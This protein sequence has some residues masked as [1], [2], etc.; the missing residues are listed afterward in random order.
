MIVCLM[1]SQL[2]HKTS[3]NID[4]YTIPPL[5]LA[6]ADEPG[7]AVVNT[8]PHSSQHRIRDTEFRT[9]G[10]D[11]NYY[12]N[13]PNPPAARNAASGIRKSFSR[14]TCSLCVWLRSIM[15]SISPRIRIVRTRSDFLII[16][17]MLCC[18]YHSRI[19]T[20]TQGAQCPRHMS[21]ACGPREV[22]WRAGDRNLRSLTGKTVRR[23]VP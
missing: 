11:I 4:L 15:W 16:E 21:V 3:H 10:R 1:A 23:L 20:S 7:R 14:R 6:M 18:R 5:H 17:L 12:Y 13:S 22:G 9:A 19:W 2:L 8:L